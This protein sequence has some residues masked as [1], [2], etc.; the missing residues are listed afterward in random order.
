VGPGEIWLKQSVF[1]V[2]DANEGMIGGA[3]VKRTGVF[4]HD[5]CGKEAYSSLAM[6]VEQGFQAIGKAGLFDEPNVTWFRSEPATE[7]QLLR[8]HSQD[9]IDQVK[10]TKWY[11]VSLY[12]VGGMI[13]ATEKV[14]SGEIDNALVIAGTGGH[15]AHRDNA[16]GGCYFSVI[17]MG[18]PHARAKGLGRRFAIVDTD[19]HHA[20]GVR[21]LYQNDDDMLHICFCDSFSWVYSPDDRMESDTKF[22][23][24]HGANDTEELEN[25]KREVPKRIKAFQP[26]MIFYLCGM[27]THQDSYGTAALTEKAYPALVEI[28]KG[29]ADEYCGGRLIVK[30]CCNAPP[31]ATT[32]AVPRMV[33]CLAETGKFNQ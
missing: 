9:W 19:T 24:P 22:C 3:T 21:D 2:K 4:Y 17:G 30:T 33:D 5:I 26:E 28:M 31:H 13:G 12:S 11:N 15:H 23:F 20:D 16:W 8:L 18:I 27:D 6:G 7:E 14:L 32:Y 25:V 1:L 29:V 10:Q